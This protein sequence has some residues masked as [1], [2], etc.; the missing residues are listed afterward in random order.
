MEANIAGTRAITTSHMIRSTDEPLCTCGEELI[1]NKSE[2]ASGFM[3]RID[4]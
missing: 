1:T 3:N 2:E 4:Y